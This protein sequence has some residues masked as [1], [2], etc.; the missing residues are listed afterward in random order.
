MS[1]RTTTEVFQD[2]LRLRIDGRLEED[3][4]RNYAE[5]VV[6]L[7]ENSVLFGHEAIRTSAE[8]LAY[9][10]PEGRFEFTAQQVAGEYAFL[11]WRGESEG[12]SLKNGADSFVIRDGKIRMQSIYYEL[13]G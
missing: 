8:R 9:Q 1:E 5:D 7:T 3:I 13:I 12:R 2:H 4:A 6:L 10:F 11:V